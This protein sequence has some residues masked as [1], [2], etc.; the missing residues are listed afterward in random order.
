MRIG[1]SMHYWITP[2]MLVCVYSWDT[3][4]PPLPSGHV[5]QPLRAHWPHLRA[6]NR[7]EHNL[8]LNSFAS[9]L[10]PCSC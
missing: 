3:G 1:A 6:I 9:Y 7:T 8:R 5:T 2:I 4:Q 10:P